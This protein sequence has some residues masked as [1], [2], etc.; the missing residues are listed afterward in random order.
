MGTPVLGMRLAQ[1]G[2]AI[3]R[4]DAHAPRERRHMLAPDL[5][6][7]LLEQIP[8]HPAAGKGVFKV[9]FV[10]ATHPR[11]PR[12]ARPGTAPS[13]GQGLRSIP[14]GLLIPTDLRSHP[15]QPLSRPSPSPSL[16]RDPKT[17]SQI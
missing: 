5:K 2:L 7:L 3:Q 12:L 11:P 10:D 16:A 1:M 4:L 13:T 17:P 14:S 9:Q 6:A 15:V 8:Q